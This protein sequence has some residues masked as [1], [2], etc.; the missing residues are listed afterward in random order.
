MTNKLVQKIQAEAE[1]HMFQKLLNTQPFPMEYESYPQYVIAHEQ[2]IFTIGE[3][4]CH[5]T[6]VLPMI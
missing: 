2:W 1:A 6:E 3:V 4:G 5:G